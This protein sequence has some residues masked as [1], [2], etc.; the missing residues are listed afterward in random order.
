LNFFAKEKKAF[1]HYPFPAQEPLIDLSRPTKRG[2]TI[3]GNTHNVS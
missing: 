2:T 1:D 3:L